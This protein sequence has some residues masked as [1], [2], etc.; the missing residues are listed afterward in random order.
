MM[1]IWGLILVGGIT[2]FA[3]VGLS[4]GFGANVRAYLNRARARPG[5]IKAMG[6]DE[7][8]PDWL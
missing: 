3:I 1:V 7:R 4:H 5:F 2:Y 6:V 8:A